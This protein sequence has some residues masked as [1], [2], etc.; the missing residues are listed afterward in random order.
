MGIFS[1][2]VTTNRQLP[3]K[4]ND[5]ENKDLGKEKKLE[6]R[7]LSWIIGAVT[8]SIFLITVSVIC[9][10]NHYSKKRGK[11]FINGNHRGRNQL[12]PDNFSDVI[13]N[14]QV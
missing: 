9:G 6:K 8:F 14:E 11:W 4:N 12:Q 1:L 10:V 2:T 3:V 5:L 13:V 7:Q